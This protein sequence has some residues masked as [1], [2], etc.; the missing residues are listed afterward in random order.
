MVNGRNSFY[1]LNPTGDLANTQKRITDFV[2]QFN[3]HGL[4]G[5]VPSRDQIRLALTEN[6][7]F[8][9]VILKLL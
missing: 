7:L 6:E 9:L 4:I 2:G 1:V 8:L 3:W 5:Q